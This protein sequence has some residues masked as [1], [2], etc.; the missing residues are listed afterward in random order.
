MVRRL[1]LPVLVIAATAM[2][3][4]SESVS[5]I[6]VRS[7]PAAVEVTPQAAGRHLVRLPALEFLLEIE[8]QCDNNMRAESLSISVADTRETVAFTDNDE[9]IITTTLTLPRQQTAPLAVVDF[10]RV[11]ED[12]S[13]GSQELLVRDAFTAHLSLRCTSDEQQS[14]VYASQS[15]DLTLLC[16]PLDQDPSADSAT[17]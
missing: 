6:K 11:D 3:V 17:R 14:G 9:R 12:Q 1:I 5:L 15:L 7:E 10:C 2:P 16:K 8:P 13:L 4:Q